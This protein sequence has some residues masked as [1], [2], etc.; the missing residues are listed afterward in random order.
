MKSKE[1][2]IKELERL[3]NNHYW[4][5]QAEPS[6]LYKSAKTLM[7]ERIKALEWVLESEK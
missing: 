7:E 4:I 1:I 6:L 3:K 2:I 5:F